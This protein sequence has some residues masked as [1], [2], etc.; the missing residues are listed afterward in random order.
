M[1]LK[2]CQSAFWVKGGPAQD[3]YNAHLGRA[4][5]VLSRS[6]AQQSRSRSQPLSAEGSERLNGRHPALIKVGSSSL[7]QVDE[8]TIGYWTSKCMHGMNQTEAEYPRCIARGPKQQVC[9]KSA[10]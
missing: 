6:E 1:R 4:R 10:Q 2:R 3:I 8:F 5:W 7:S 9:A